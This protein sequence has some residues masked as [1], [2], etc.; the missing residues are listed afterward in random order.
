MQN[1]E[2]ELAHLLKNL[3]VP[4]YACDPCGLITHF[5]QHAVRLWGRVPSLNN[6]ADRFCGSPRIFALDG[7]PIAHDQC[8]M[9]LALKTDTECTG[10]EI[11]L[12]RE[13]GQHVVALAYVEPIHDKSGKLMGAV[14]IL[15][16]IS[17]QNEVSQ[18]LQNEILKCRSLEQKFFEY[19]EREQSR[20]THHLHEDLGQQ[21]T[22]I[23]LLVRVLGR[24]LSEESHAEVDRVIELAQL[25]SECISTA[26]NLAKNS[27]PLELDHGGLI[28]ALEDLAIRTSSLFK[29][30]CKILHDN[31]F[32]YKQSSAIHL[33][34]IAQE[35][36]DNAVKR[37]Y[38]RNIMVECKAR[39]GVMSLAVTNDGISFEMLSTM[40]RGVDFDLMHSRARLFGAHLEIRECTIGG[41]VICWLDNEAFQQQEV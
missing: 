31:S 35:L 1:S 22:G 37:A 18:S 41:S 17:A 40:S 9:A 21:L 24:R 4:A 2:S 25:V 16:D 30:S 27:Y 14:G 11:I 34:R 6:P 29:I 15:V 3:P 28:M 5:N 38:A 12:Q 32:Q 8:Y 10:T 39:N 13:N 33:Y 36:I 26:R 23:A 20:L 19:S 7:S